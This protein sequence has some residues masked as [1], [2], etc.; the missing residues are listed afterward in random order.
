MTEN[1]NYISMA[2]NQIRRATGSR[3]APGESCEHIRIT[4]PDREL[5]NDYYYIDPNGPLNGI[6]DAFQVYCRFH[7]NHAE[8]CVP[9]GSGSFKDQQWFKNKRSSAWFANEFA[10]G[11]EVSYCM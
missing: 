5:K 1:L 9:A 7:E 8:S 3:A 6:Q 2:I 10:S 11:R 4:N